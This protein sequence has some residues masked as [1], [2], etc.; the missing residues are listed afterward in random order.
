MEQLGF[1]SFGLEQ[2]YIAISVGTHMYGLK[3][4]QIINSDM[5]SY[6]KKT[7][8]TF[9]VVSFLSVLHHFELDQHSIDP[10]EIIKM[11]DK[12]TNKVLFF[13][14]GQSHEKAFG[15]KLSKWTDD[16]IIDWLKENTTFKHIIDLGKDEDNIPPFEG[17]YSRT[18]F[19]CI[20]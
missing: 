18:L 5:V 8:T 6:L 14:T 13:E 2:D 3:Q 10:E 17:Y 4:E 11:I 9:D 20:R 1:D 19:A 15:E 12:L 16:F 7:S